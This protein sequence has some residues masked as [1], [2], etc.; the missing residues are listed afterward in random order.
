[1]VPVDAVRRR[2]ATSAEIV[3][4]RPSDPDVTESVDV[5]IQGRAG[6]SEIGGDLVIGDRYREIAEQLRRD[7][8]QREASGR[9]DVP[10][11]FWRPREHGVDGQHDQEPQRTSVNSA[12]YGLFSRRARVTATG[13][14]GERRLRRH[15]TVPRQ[16]SADELAH[17][18]E[19]PPE[20]IRH[21]GVDR[22]QYD[23]EEEADIGAGVGDDEVTPRDRRPASGARLPRDVVAEG[24]PAHHRD[25]ADHEAVAPEGADDGGH[26]A[27]A[28]PFPVLERV[29]NAEVSLD[30]DGEQREHRGGDQE[31]G[32]RHRDQAEIGQRQAE[33]R[34]LRRLGRDVYRHDRKPEQQV[35]GRQRYDERVRRGA[36]VTVASDGQDQRRVADH[37]ERADHRQPDVFDPE[38][39]AQRQLAADVLRCRRSVSIATRVPRF[40]EHS[41]PACASPEA[42][43]A[44]LQMADGWG[45]NASES[46]MG[47]NGAPRRL[48]QRR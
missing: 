13:T 17:G 15:A 33:L 23:R 11:Q 16:P 44:R 24:V 14:V 47:L 4:E 26:R 45:K 25:R 34:P 18:P 41:V 3:E 12:Q 5:G 10:D 40:V 48:R 35:G 9:G 6:K 31:A 39:V 42:V 8:R 30:G 21:R 43:A 7:V 1:M 29:Q 46:G 38:T 32:Q 2:T 27:R 22:K 19:H 36:E 28:S 37:R 20:Q